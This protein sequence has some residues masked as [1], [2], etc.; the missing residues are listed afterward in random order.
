[1]A[2][3]VPEGVEQALQVLRR[4]LGESLIAAY[5][6]GSAVKGGLR[7]T[8]DIDLLAVVGQPTSHAIRSQL[9]TELMAISSPPGH[10]PGRR[11]LEVIVF[12]HADLEAFTHPARSEF[13]YGEWLRE[14]FEAG[15]VPEP[16][17]DPEL[18][19]VLAQARREA[20]T[21]FGSEPAGCLPVISEGDIARAI[22]DVLPSLLDS[23]EGDER[24]VLLT[25]ARMWRTLA[26][27]GFVP[28]DVAAKWAMPR[29]PA[30]AASIIEAA[31]LDYLGLERIAWASRRA[32]VGRV[33]T[34]LGERIA[35][36]V[37][38]HPT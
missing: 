30:E 38:H 27:G 31:R 37:D 5:L 9:L 12:R 19:L 25:L 8:S 3:P 33:A 28:K 16:A 23:L 20:V 29:L 6:H 17:R 34:D 14:A 24:N 11:A 21:L 7:P 22:A 32:S 35:A 13:V 36:L 26:E 2:A 4:R 10:A 1:M 18:T 15:I